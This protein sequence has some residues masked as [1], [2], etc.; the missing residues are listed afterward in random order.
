M[1]KAPFEKILELNY[2][3]VILYRL[4][5]ALLLFWFSRL[6][7]YLFN[8][9]YFPHLSFAEVVR[10][11]IFGL[12]F[13]VSALM[14]LNAPF[15]ILMALPIPLRRTKVWRGMAGFI[16]YTANIM[17][18]MAN[19]MDLVYFRFTQKRMTG[20]IFAYA[21]EDVDVVGLMPQ[22]IKDYW[23]YQLSFLFFAVLLVI[24]CRR[25][26]Y[27]PRK[28]QLTKYTNL[29]YQFFAFIILMAAIIVGIRGGFQLKPIN[30]ITA[31]KVSD[32]QNSAFVLNTPF[33]IIKTLNMDRLQRKN[34][35]PGAECKAIFNPVYNKDSVAAEKAIFNSKNV[36]VLIIESLSSEHIGAFNRNKNN[37]PGFTPFLDSLIDH[38]VAFQGYANGKQSIEGIPSIVSSLPG[39]MDWPYINSAYAGNEINTLASLLNEKGYNTAFYHGGTNGTM[40]FDGFADIAGFQKYY[41]RF[42]YNNDK[43]YDGNWGIFD[44]PFYN[45][46]ADNLTKTPEPFFATFFSLSSHHPYTIPEKYKGKFRDGNL[47]IQKAIMYAD[48]SLGKF[49]QKAS[50]L[51]WY[52]ETIFVIT[53]DHTSESYLD[54]YSTRVGMYQIPLIFFMPGLDLETPKG[55]TAAQVDIMP[56]VLGLLNYKNPFVAF[57]NDLFCNDENSFAVN[58]TSGSYQIIQQNFALHFDGEKAT[59]LYNFKDDPLLQHNLKNKQIKKVEQM[60]KLLKAYIQQYNKR[61][62]ENKLVPANDDHSE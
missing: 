20:D 1:Q 25:V 18:L 62:I 11:L 57:G 2:Y 22:F 23:F 33:T 45:Y 28:K 32:A 36:V 17:G 34:Y 15:I 6:F 27:R 4:G 19:F 44:E 55:K 59:A 58:Y 46:F 37:Y 49:F 8:L 7:F 3:R 56:S 12:R 54:K 47:E 10:I 41:G 61:M 16:F 31:G 21:S 43:D 29:G 5:V 30:I 48:Y 35:F 52:D 53:A 38:A 9:N 50:K 40:D 60:G 13:D 42:E 14:M 39:L 24:L 26:K 51:S